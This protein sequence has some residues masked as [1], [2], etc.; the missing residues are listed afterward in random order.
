MCPLNFQNRN[1]EENKSEAEDP[2][3]RSQP[4]WVLEFDSK[5]AQMEKAS[6]LMVSLH[7][8]ILQREDIW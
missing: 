5:R 1:P 8:V 6:L 7:L 3:S 4:D 2:S